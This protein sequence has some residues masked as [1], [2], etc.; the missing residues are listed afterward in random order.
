MKRLCVFFVL[1]SMVFMMTGCRMYVDYVANGDGTVTS[2]GMTAYT[3]EELESMGADEKAKA[4]LQTLEDGKQYYVVKENPETK[5][6]ARV[7]EEDGILITE[8]MCVYMIGDLETTLDGQVPADMMYLQLSVTLGSDIVDTN[9]NVLKEGKKAV[10]ASSATSDS[11][12]YAY[13]QK[14]KELIEQDKTAPKMIGAK[15]N[16]YFREM[17]QTITFTDEIMVKEVKLNGVMVTCATSTITTDKGTEKK[18]IWYTP[19]GS[20]PAKKGKNVFEVTDLNNNV[21]TYTIFVDGKQPVIKGV[22]ENKSYKKKAT[23]Y[24]KDDLLLSKVKINGKKQKITKKQLVKSGKY[25][26]YYKYTVKKNGTN[27]IVVTDKAG[28][29]KTMKINIVK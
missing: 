8:D 1:M 9:A 10:F 3:P 26:G 11:Y 15:N 13:T 7:K 5:S 17:P 14:G 29:T 27:K 18:Y 19:N 12:W 24:V 23:V 20:E 28:N 6:M 22:K 2:N 25:K 4:S 21:A 16:Q